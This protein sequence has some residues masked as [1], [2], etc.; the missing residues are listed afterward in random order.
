[1]KAFRARRLGGPEAMTL[2]E[3]SG[4]KP[5]AGEVVIAVHATGVHLADLAAAAGQREP[6][7]AL[8]FVPGLEAAGTV[9]SLGEGV[10]GFNM[11]ERVVAFLPWGGLAESAIATA[12]CCVALPDAL[13]FAVAACLPVAYGGALIAL[14][15]IANLAAGETLLVLGAGGQA[16]MAAIEIGK[17]LGARVAAAASGGERSA[18][19]GALGADLAI[20]TS[21]NA[22]KGA[23]DTFTDS[24]GADVVF[25][26]V[27]GEALDAALGAS[28]EGARILAAG[29]A[30]GQTSRLNVQA[31]FARG[32]RLLSANTPHYVLQ[33]PDGAR[34]AL[35]QVVAWTAEGKL[36]PRIAAQFPLVQAGAALDYVRSRRGSGAVIVDVRE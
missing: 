2:E 21:A 25:D 19:A 23:L 9:E 18:A 28:A 1:M 17:L 24:K 32:A 26:P 33:N 10:K 16:G 6:V 34:A 20:D 4:P 8:P 22:L 29:F 3:V 5:A 36:K 15:D 14:R 35:E 7:P 27:G 12:D 13:S 30:S 31:L 11:G